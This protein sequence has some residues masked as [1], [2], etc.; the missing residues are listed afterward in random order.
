MSNRP[1][2]WV[3]KEYDHSYDDIMPLTRPKSKNHPPMS[4]GA[5]AAQFSPYDA[6]TGYSDE[7]KETARITD[8]RV[9]LSA[10]DQEALDRK[11]SVLIEAVTSAGKHGEKP[12]V[13]ILYF[14]PDKKKDGGSF[15][16]VTGIVRTIDT[17]NRE[18][19]LFKE[20]L[21]D[22][23]KIRMDD[24]VDIQSTLFQDIENNTQSVY[25][26]RSKKRS[27]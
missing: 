9:E 7:I 13:A 15:K 23:M 4:M 8:G 27:I 6:L 5:R 22:S 10:E 24:V 3:E 20:K 25:I 26:S 14:V 12:T 19:T 17:A 21:T 2:T 16:E 18:I 11:L 1:Y